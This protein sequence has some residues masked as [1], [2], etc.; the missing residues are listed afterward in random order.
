MV[1]LKQKVQR[2]EWRSG[3]LLL[4]LSALFPLRGVTGF[5]AGVLLND[6]EFAAV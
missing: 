2:I 1:P 5:S 6:E 4:L 3:P